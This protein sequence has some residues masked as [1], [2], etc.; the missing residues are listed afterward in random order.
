MRYPIVFVVLAAGAIQSVTALAWPQTGCPAGQNVQ[1]TWTDL[2]IC[3]AVT[4]A[5]SIRT[6]TRRPFTAPE[7]A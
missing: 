6:M 4:L 5:L 7:P 3:F 2:V 1:S